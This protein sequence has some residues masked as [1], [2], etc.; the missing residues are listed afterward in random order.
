[1]CIKDKTVFALYLKSNIL[2]FHAS[3]FLVLFLSNK[4]MTYLYIMSYKHFYT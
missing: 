4:K 3:I 1:M 2:L